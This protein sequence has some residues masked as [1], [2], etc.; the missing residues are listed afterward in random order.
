MERKAALITGGSERIG[1]SI[2][3]SF[4]EKGFDIAIHYS[5]SET[6]AEGAKLEIENEGV[7]CLI[8]K[9]DFSDPSQVKSLVTDV[10]KELNLFCIV[11]NASVFEPS[12]LK[13]S[14]YTEFEN[15]FNINFFAPFILTREFAKNVLKGHIINILDTK[16]SQNKTEHFNYLLTKKFLQSFTEMS[17]VQLAPGIRVNGI[18]L[19]P[20]LPPP[21]KDV[22][23]L[24][25]VASKTPIGIPGS[26]KDIGD[27]IKYFID[28]E[29]VTGQIIYLDGGENL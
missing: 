24:K 2:A 17:A 19:G 6:K 18:A 9:N 14:N 4:A 10:F 28:N 12:S 29:Y 5:R 13:E 7:R 27:T 1:K 15:T 11:N 3:L 21:G 16:I 26:L 25:E 23:Y 20:I 22:N 8:F